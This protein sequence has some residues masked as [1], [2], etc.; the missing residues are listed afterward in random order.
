M[1]AG[2]GA[3]TAFAREHGWQDHDALRVG[4]ELSP[5]EE[6]TYVFDLG[7]YWRHQCRVLDEKIDSREF[8]G[9]GAS[10]RHPVPIFGWGWIPDQHGRTT[11]ED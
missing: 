11:R 3:P 7:D 1:A 6:F 10:P 2:F 5:G 4:T 8:F 9:E